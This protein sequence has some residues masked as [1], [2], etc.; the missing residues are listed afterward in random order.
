MQAMAN[1]KA[2]QQYGISDFNQHARQAGIKYHEQ[3]Q[4]TF[5]KDNQTFKRQNGEYT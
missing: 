4:G 3:Y 1:G 2:H 5:A